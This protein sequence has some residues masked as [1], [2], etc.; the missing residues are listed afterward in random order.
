MKPGS[1]EG[2]VSSQGREREAHGGTR[3]GAAQPIPLLVLGQG[4]PPAASAVG[5]RSRSPGKE[6]PAL[7][8]GTV[9]IASCG[10]LPWVCRWTQIPAS[11]N[12]TE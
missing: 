1:A 10:L 4:L 12:H 9:L 5:W 2:P 11:R 6:H 8:L 3:H 7:D